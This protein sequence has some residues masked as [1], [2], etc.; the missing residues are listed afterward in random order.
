MKTLKIEWKHLDVEGETCD[1]CYDTGENLANEVK[2]LNRA[3]QS[4]GIE[5]EWIETKLD[6]TQIPQSNMLLFNGVP[7]EDILNIEVSENYCDSCTTLLGAETYCRTVRYEGN[8]YED[9]PAKAIRQ[10]ALKVMGIDEEPPAE[11]SCC[12]CNSSG[13]C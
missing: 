13:C 9:I 8:E 2:R 5:V 6:D 3:L 12:S 7:I 11:K 10:A 4:K 1:R